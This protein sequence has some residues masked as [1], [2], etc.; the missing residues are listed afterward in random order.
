MDGDQTSKPI[1]QLGFLFIL[2]G[3]DKQ[4]IKEAISIF[5][6]IVVHGED[7]ARYSILLYRQFRGCQSAYKIKTS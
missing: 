7:Y 3:Y 4:I 5:L 6:D 1:K 2:S